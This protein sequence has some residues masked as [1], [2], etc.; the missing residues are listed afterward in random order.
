MFYLGESSITWQS[1]KQKLVALSSCEAE[2]MASSA[3]ACQAIWLAGLLSEILGAPG[4]PL[5][6]K[7]DNKSA[8]DLIKNPVHHGQSKHIKIRYHLVR[9]CTAEGRIEIQLVGTNDQLTDILIKPLPRVRFT[10]MK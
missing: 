7:I 8:I 2:H 6:L 3:A 4:K 5:L 10:E 1:Q 9:E